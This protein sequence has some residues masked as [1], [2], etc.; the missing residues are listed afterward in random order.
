MP[1]STLG[2]GRRFPPIPAIMLAAVFVTGSA[3]PRTTE[4]SPEMPEPTR[5]GRTPW[6][7]SRVVGSP[8][9]PPPFKV[10][11]AFPNLKFDHPLAHRALS[12]ERPACSSAS[13][14]A[15]CIRS[16]TTRTP[17]PSSFSTC[18]RNSRRFTCSPGRRSVEAVYGLA[19]HPRIRAEPPVLRLLYPARLGP[20]PA[21]SRGRHARV[22]VHGHRRPTRRG[23]TR[24]A[25]RSSSPSCRAATTAA[26]STSAPTAC[27]TFP[28][29]TRRTRTRPTRSTPGRTSPTCSR[30]SCGSTWTARTRAKNYAIPKD[31]PFVAMKGARPEVWAYGLRNPWRMSFDRQTGEL[32]VGD[33]GWELWEMVHRVEKRRQLRLVGHGR[34][35]ADQAGARSGRRRSTRR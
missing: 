25:R 11:R 18:A 1:S 22:A 14:P 23:S 6:T 30:P 8:D 19:F 7:T 16:P 32:F 34:A 10:V 24:R 5:S 9:P 3:R 27:S 15:C 21:E 33:V 2:G 12:G 13:R 26:T 31:N 17:G 20:R 29:A 35:A 4:G 28:P